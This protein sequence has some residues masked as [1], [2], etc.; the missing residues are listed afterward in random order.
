MNREKNLMAKAK[1]TKVKNLRLRRRIRKTV[2]A[3]FMAS[4]V[5][6]AAIPVQDIEAEDLKANGVTVNR[7][8]AVY[9]VGTDASFPNSDALDPTQVD[10]K[11]IF[12]SY[13]VRKLSDDSYSLNWQFKYYIATIDGNQRAIISEYNDLYQEEEVLLGNSANKGYYMVEESKL[14]E[15]Y[16]TGAGHKTVT[17]TYDDIK[18]ADIGQQIE[19]VSWF[20]KYAK[21]NYDKYKA[22]CDAYDEYLAK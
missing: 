1:E 4:A 20:Q 16:T 17:L 15:F 21:D 13:S 10:G 5:A 9:K 8:T 22:A 12:T 14:D 3:L 19:G 2:G 18:K 6:V 7:P 11:D